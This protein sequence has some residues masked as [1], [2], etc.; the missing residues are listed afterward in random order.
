MSRFSGHVNRVGC[1]PLLDA[2]WEYPRKKN[3]SPQGEQ[4]S[5][6]GVSSLFSTYSTFCVE[7]KVLRRHKKVLQAC[8][9]ATL[10]PMVNFATDSAMKLITFPRIGGEMIA[11]FVG[12]GFPFLG[13]IRRWLLSR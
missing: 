7:I 5:I 3:C 11:Q 1:T 13:I 4:P 12:D 6:A 2:S 10:R 8:M 9:A